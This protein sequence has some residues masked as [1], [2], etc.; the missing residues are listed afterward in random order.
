MILRR[1]GRVEGPRAVVALA[2]ADGVVGG[3][4]V[5]GAVGARGVACGACGL[6]AA[7][8]DVRAP[9]ALT[10]ARAAAEEGRR[11]GRAG[12]V[13][14]GGRDLHGRPDPLQRHDRQGQEGQWLP[15]LLQA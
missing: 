4:K 8:V 2:P 15:P 11:R 9:R 6:R 13:P 5:A 12:A 14:G 1:A 7:R 10:H 3:R